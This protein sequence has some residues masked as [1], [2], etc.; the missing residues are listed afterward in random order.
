MSTVNSVAAGLGTSVYASTEDRI[1]VKTLNQN[2]FLKLLV[3]QMT[4]QDPLNPDS[5][6]LNSIA[7]MASFSSLEQAKAMQSE[8]AQL[9]RDQELVKANSLLG[10]TVDIQVDASTR[11]TGVVTAVQVEAGTPKVV[12]G[13]G[14]Y[15]MSQLL[16]I[17]PTI[18]GNQTSTP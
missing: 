16:S 4:Q 7:Q 17:T 5:Q 12:V 3:A 18:D 1:P 9:R 15:D 10:R 2:D 6:G 14:S 8:I 11:L 13:G